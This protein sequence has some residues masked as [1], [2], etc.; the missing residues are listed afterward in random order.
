MGT[1]GQDRTFDADSDGPV[2]ESS[3]HAINARADAGA[4]QI[5]QVELGAT[6]RFAMLVWISAFVAAAATIGLIVSIMFIKANI[7]YT[8]VL[9]Y[10]LMDLRSKMGLAHENTPAPIESDEGE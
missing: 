9:E 3:P 5:I 2:T 4:A 1:N 10:D 8:A 7:S 6:K